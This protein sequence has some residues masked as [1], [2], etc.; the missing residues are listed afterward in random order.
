MIILISLP[1]ACRNVDQFKA[2]R[3]EAKREGAAASAAAKMKE[4]KSVGGNKKVETQNKKSKSPPPQEASKRKEVIAA[5]GKFGEGDVVIYRHKRTGE[6]FKMRITKVVNKCKGYAFKLESVDGT[7]CFKGVKE[8]DLSLPA[9]G[10]VT[11]AAVEAK[12]LAVASTS[13]VVRTLVDFCLLA[14][15]KGLELFS[16]A[17][18]QL[19]AI[20]SSGWEKAS[21]YC[22]L[23]CSKGLELFSAAFVQLRAILSS[24]WEKASSYCLLAC[25]KGLELFSAAFVESRAILSSGWEKASSYL[26]EA[27]FSVSEFLQDLITKLTGFAGAVFQNTWSF[28][29]VSSQKL[30][31]VAVGLFGALALFCTGSFE[32]VSTAVSGFSLPDGPVITLPG[33]SFSQIASKCQI[34]EP[35]STSY[36]SLVEKYGT[37]AVAGGSVVSLVVAFM[38][39]SAVWKGISSVGD[40]T[41]DAA[42]AK[43]GLKYELEEK[44]KPERA[45]R[46]WVREE[47]QEEE[48]K[49][50]VKKEAAVKQVAKEEVKPAVEK[51][52]TVKVV[53]REETVTEDDQK[54]ASEETDKGQAEDPLKSIGKG[55]IN[56]TKVWDRSVAKGG[57]NFAKTTNTVLYGKEVAEEMAAEREPEPEIERESE[58]SRLERLAERANWI[59]RYRARTK[60][61]QLEKERT[62]EAEAAAQAEATATAGTAE[63]DP[64]SGENVKERSSWI[65]NWRSGSSS[66]RL[67]ERSGEAAVTTPEEEEAKKCIEV[68]LDP[69]G[70]LKKW[71]REN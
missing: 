69:V 17:F 63:V 59:G 57:K 47:L 29:S 56:F 15:S 5:L 25:S 10:K 46:R 16:A 18:V 12:D 65:K 13:T 53:G 62:R 52:G 9:L 4:R 36:N 49:P 39:L 37:P 48:V 66:N 40:R 19:R 44:K 7:V 43:K 42:K 35:I 38:T 14:C 11:R 33:W 58:E 21:S 31:N 51:K 30:A 68:K 24:G 8:E 27:D 28:I 6:A 23:A 26:A 32:K 70:G 61:A 22:L 1:R 67:A 50:A 55:I 60:L 41:D 54:E 45:S 34:P 64:A 3:E 71:L 2:R 20:L